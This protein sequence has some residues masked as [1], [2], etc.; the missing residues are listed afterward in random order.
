M[1]FVSHSLRIGDGLLLLTCTAHLLH[2]KL[3]LFSLGLKKIQLSE[4]N[5]SVWDTDQT[6][7]VDCSKT[8]GSE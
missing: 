8:K 2:K 5:G 4:I 3:I 7:V 1:L 6:V